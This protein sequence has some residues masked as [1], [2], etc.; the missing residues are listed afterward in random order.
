MAETNLIKTDQMVKIQNKEFLTRFQEN[1]S[2]LTRVLGLTNPIRK[3][4]GT[5]LKMYKTTGE[6]NTANAAE[7]EDIPLS[8]YQRV[9]VGTTELTIQKR[10][11]ATTL[12]AIANYGYEEAVSKTDEQFIRDIQKG[13]LSD[14][15]GSLATGRTNISEATLQGLFAQMWAQM[16]VMFQDTTATPVYFVNPLDIA[17]YVGAATVTDQTQFGAAYL[18]QFTGIGPVVVDSLVPVGTVYGTA[19]ENL[20]LYYLDPA[21]IQ[22]FGFATQQPGY[23]GVKHTPFD[24]NVTLRTTAV[25]GYQLWAEYADRIVIGTIG[26]PSYAAV[27]KDTAIDPSATYYTRSGRSGHYVYT[28]ADTAG[29]E[30]APANTYYT[31]G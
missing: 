6:L 25:Y 29:V 21:S 12:E 17:D 5:V 14:F 10:A 15:Y 8:E 1:L 22:G 2:R 16:G 4:A 23:I 3:Q 9:V 26:S 31:R 30:K 7:G 18:M 19:T 11:K 24:K 20:N 27:A 13:I 28:V